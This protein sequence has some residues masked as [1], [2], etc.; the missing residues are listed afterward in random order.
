MA[1]RKIQIEDIPAM[2]DGGSIRG[3]FKNN[4]KGFYIGPDYRAKYVDPRLIHE[5]DSLQNTRPLRQTLEYNVVDPVRDRIHYLDSLQQ[6]MINYGKK[7]D[8]IPV[9]YKYGG[10]LAHNAAGWKKQYG[11][12][13][14]DGGPLLPNNPSGYADSVINA[15][16]NIPFYRDLKNGTIP[17]QNIENAGM[18][19]SEGIRGLEDDHAN[20]YTGS[21]TG[22]KPYMRYNNN[23]YIPMSGMKETYEDTTIAPLHFPSQRSADIFDNEIYKRLTKKYGGMTKKMWAGGNPDDEGGVSLSSAN[24]AWGSSATNNQQ[25]M[26]DTYAPVAQANQQAI[27]MDANSYANRPM[28][29]QERANMNETPVAGAENLNNPYTQ[30]QGAEQPT[31]PTVPGQPKRPFGTGY[32]NLL[33]AAMMYGQYAADRRQDKAMKAYGIKQGMTQM[34]P[35]ATGMNKGQYN[36]QGQ[37]QQQFS[38]PGRF[39]RYGGSM[40]PEYAVGGEY[41][42]DDATIEALSRKGYK[43]KYM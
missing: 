34:N 20:I 39:G 10:V 3:I 7:R 29:T 38:A 2:Q 25:Q 31:P 42:M 36:Q 40:Q 30:Q 18:T 8:G 19:F 1:K 21:P 43:I 28:V 9:G 11:G 26:Q 37:L 35:V 15:N 5:M 41:E 32:R 24:D 23:Q 6:E 22:Y 12:M 16:Q 27:Q 13:Y 14:A 17:K 33:G 4:D